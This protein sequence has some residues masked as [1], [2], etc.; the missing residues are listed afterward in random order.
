MIATMTM[1]AYI[2]CVSTPRLRPISATMISIPPRAFIPIAT[3]SDSR[4]LS[5]KSRAAGR[6]PDQ[7]AGDRDSHHQRQQAKPVQGEEIDLESR[8]GEEDRRENPDSDRLEFAAIR[9][10]QPRRPAQHYAR[11]KRAEHR[12]DADCLRDN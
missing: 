12:M 2:S 3:A 5:P 9:P 1:I 7:F 4:G 10:S 6:P 8:I 11:D